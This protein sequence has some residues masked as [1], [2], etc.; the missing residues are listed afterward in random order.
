[1]F[2]ETVSPAIGQATKQIAEIKPI[3]VEDLPPSDPNRPKPPSDPIADSD[4]QKSRGYIVASALNRIWSILL[5]G[6]NASE[7]IE[8]WQKTYE[9]LKPHIGPIIEF[10]KDF[11]PPGGGSGPSLP[12]TIGT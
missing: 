9:L 4:P 10:L 7:A 2:D 1:M 5:K 12:P 8:G 11:L 3:Q 6:K